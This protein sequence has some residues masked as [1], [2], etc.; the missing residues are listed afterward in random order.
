MKVD[1]TRGA[2]PT[3]SRDDDKPL[4]V[5]TDCSLA[6][7]RIKKENGA[8]AKHPIELLAEAYGLSGWQT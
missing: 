2:W 8:E 5:V 7:L 4:T 1:A 3:P 6:A